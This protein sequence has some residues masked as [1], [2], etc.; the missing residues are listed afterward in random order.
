MTVTDIT[1]LGQGKKRIYL[2]GEYAFPL[3]NKE[4]S[5][6]KIAIGEEISESKLEEISDLIIHR[7]KERIL[8]LIGDMARTESNVRS[9]LIQSGYT[10]EYIFPAIEEI[11]SLGYIDDKSYAYEYASSLV[12]N[13]GA[14]RLIVEQKLFQR[15]ISKEI[16]EETIA[17]IDFDEEELIERAILKK[18]FE[19]AD[20]ENLAVEDKRRLYAYLLRKGFS[21]SSLRRFF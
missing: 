18:G 7:I 17:E 13:K 4:I 21:T 11:K 8:Y 16:I 10:E 2:D 15:G 12:T 6:Y 3:Y 20:I 14:S 5:K 19:I 1:D 9:K